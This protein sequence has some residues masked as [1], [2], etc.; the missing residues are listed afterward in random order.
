AL[1]PEA[2]AHRR[3]AQADHRLPADVVERVAEANRR[4]RLALARGRRA[5]RRDED[6]LAVRPVPEAVHV[7]ER[8]LRLVVAVGAELRGFDAELLAR[9]LDDRP[10]RRM[11]R[12]LD[13]RERRLVLVM[14][15]L[16][17]SSPLHAWA[18]DRSGIIRQGP[19][20]GIWYIKYKTAET[21]E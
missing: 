20:F 14:V 6:Q 8:D 19:E 16:H 21:S 5:D 1:H 13:V 11:L 2:R 18:G 9:H 3:L 12:D 17:V 10:H 15:L 7:V 4:R